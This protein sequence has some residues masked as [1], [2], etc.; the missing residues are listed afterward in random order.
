[1]SRLSVGVVTTLLVVSVLAPA[2]IGGATAQEDRVTVTVAIVDSNGESL[3]NIDVTVTWDSGSANVTTA[4]NGKAFV[5]VP[6]GSNIQIDV[7][8]DTYVRNAP[9]SVFN[10]NEQ[11][12]E[13]PVSESARATLT[14]QSLSGPVAD[15][16]ITVSSSSSTIQ[17]L[18]TDENGQATT[19]RLEEGS[20]NLRVSKPR[21]VENDTATLELAGDTNKTVQL[22]RGNVQVNFRVVDD[23]FDDPRPIEN[24]TVRVPGVYSSQTFGNGETSTSL[25]VNEDYR[26]EASKDGYNTVSRSF[27][28]DEETTDVQIAIRRTADIRIE[29]DNRRVVVGET[30]DI[31][32]TDEYGDPVTN[33]PVSIGGQ[34]VGRTDDNGELEVPIDIEGNQTVS[35]SEGSLSESVTIEGVPA[36]TDVTPTPTPSPTPSPTPTETTEQPDD[37]DEDDETTSGD[38]GPGFGALAALAALVAALALARR[39]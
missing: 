5:D 2:A 15:A 23:H 37:D 24:A 9:Y 19:R 16:D 17:R 12:I 30:T 38:D 36:G 20:Y 22:R 3:G 27:S 1:M 33:A 7:D 18:T 10:V 39:R 29:A 34:S 35:V 6:N 28:V 4:S 13:V 8:D 32:V 26:V 31:R 25:P 14:V 21:F 11:E